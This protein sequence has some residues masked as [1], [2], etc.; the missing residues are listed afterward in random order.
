MYLLVGFLGQCWVAP[1]YSTQANAFNDTS[2]SVWMWA[3]R[4]YNMSWITCW[5]YGCAPSSSDDTLVSPSWFL[6]S[7]LGHWWCSLCRRQWSLFTL[8]PIQLQTTQRL[9][10]VVSCWSGPWGSWALVSYHYD[11]KS[12]VPCQLFLTNEGLFVWK[13]SSTA[14]LCLFYCC[15]W[16][17]FASPGM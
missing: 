3:R 16:C 13:V 14:S 4:L 15:I 9:F 8:N 5:G 17:S 11:Q 12:W 2:V 7:G 6:H 10:S 1:W